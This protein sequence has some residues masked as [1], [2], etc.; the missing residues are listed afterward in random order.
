VS[1]SGMFFGLF[2][3]GGYAWHSQL[4]YLVVALLLLATFINPASYISKLHT[5]FIFLIFVAVIYFV[6]EA[7]ASVFYPAPPESLSEFFQSFWQGLEYGPC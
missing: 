2:S 4:F 3:C 5:K 6:F 1:L 7:S